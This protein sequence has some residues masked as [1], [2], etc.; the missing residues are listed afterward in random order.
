M[1]RKRRLP[2]PR[3]APPDGTIW[4]RVNYFPISVIEEAAKLHMLISDTPSWK[5]DPSYFWAKR[6]ER[7]SE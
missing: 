5:D 6:K 7:K 4:G 3:P 1:K 2:P